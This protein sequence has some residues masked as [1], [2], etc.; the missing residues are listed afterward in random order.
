MEQAEQGC[1]ACVMD[2]LRH[3]GPRQT[4]DG[5]SLDSDR[6]VLAD[7][8]QGKFVVVVQA[9]FPNLAVLNGDPMTC[10]LAVRGPSLLTGQRP[11]SSC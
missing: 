6:L 8:S 2:G 11:L 10:L 7:Q 4:G 3:P 9:R 5:Q 1:P